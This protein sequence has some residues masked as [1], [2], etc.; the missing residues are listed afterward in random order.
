MESAILLNR[1][2]EKMTQIGGVNIVKIAANCGCRDLA[3]FRGIGTCELKRI[4]KAGDIDV[5][6]QYYLVWYKPNEHG[7]GGWNVAGSQNY[8]LLEYGELT[9]KYEVSSLIESLESGLKGEIEI[10]VALDTTLNR[11]L[12]VDGTKRALALCHLKNNLLESFG[13]LLTS[14]YSIDI[15]QLNS[16]Y[17]KMLFPCDFLKL[18]A[19]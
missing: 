2:L 9:Q 6:S 8:R 1:F 5:L 16:P 11:G 18:C 10:L 17:C 14:E 19:S 15:L 4:A 12:I 13:N 3:L 7:L